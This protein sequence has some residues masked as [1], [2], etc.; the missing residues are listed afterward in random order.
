MSCEAC[1][2][3]ERNPQ[4]GH[5]YAMCDECAARALALSP[6][7]HESR[8]ERRRTDRYSQALSAMF[9]DREEHGHA[10]VLQ[11]HKRIRDH[12]KHGEA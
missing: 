8:T 5:F 4:S 7:F 10:L 6:D 2:R 11:W 9:K 3:A 1:A 12:L